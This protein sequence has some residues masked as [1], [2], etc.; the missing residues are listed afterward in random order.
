MKTLL[1]SLL[2]LF[3]F[4][5]AMGVSLLVSYLSGYITIQVDSSQ[6][7]TV[8]IIRRS[9]FPVW[10]YEQAPGYSIMRSWNFGRFLTNCAVWLSFLGIAGFMLLLVRRQRL[11]GRAG[12]S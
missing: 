12:G 5:G 8:G 3:A 1:H 2:L 6:E 11:P 4:I 7:E 10:F 9:G